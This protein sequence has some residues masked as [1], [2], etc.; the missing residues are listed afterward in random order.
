M[1]NIIHSA[2]HFSLEDEINR[3]KEAIVKL[4]VNNPSKIEI[5][6]LIAYKNKKAVMP[7]N[8]VLGFFKNMRG[9]N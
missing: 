7:K 4:G 6:A 2:Y 5:T 1:T 3:L 8:E 9:L